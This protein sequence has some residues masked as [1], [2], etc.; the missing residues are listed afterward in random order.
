VLHRSILEL[1][2]V[3]MDFDEKYVQKLGYA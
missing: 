2:A 1:T 3:G